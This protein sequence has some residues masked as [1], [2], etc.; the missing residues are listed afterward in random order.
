[1]KE[2][3]IV[4]IHGMGKTDEDFD[5]R[6]KAA[7]R[8]R[9]GDSR[10]SRIVWEKV[11]YQDILQPHQKRLMNASMVEGDVDW[12]KLRKFV[13]FGFSDAASMESRPSAPNS[14]YFQIQQIILDTLN[15]ALA[16][17]GDA[18]KPVIIIAQS[19]GC[20]VISNYIWDA[21]RKVEAGVF[22]HDAERPI[23]TNTKEG[24]FLRLKTLSHLFTSGCNIP[25]FI[26]GL[27]KEKI[28]PITV[29][30]RGW[31]IS[32]Q[33]YYDPDDALGWPLRPVNEAY[34]RTVSVDKAI[35]AGGLFNAWNPLSH[36]QYWRDDDFLDPVEDAVRQLL[37][38]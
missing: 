18:G 10:W 30:A 19:L 32:W 16:G 11:Y 6:L 1:M 22:R 20:Q 28:K 13:L 3:A 36:Q 5:H 7:L 15:R 26:A 8:D 38:R 24:K 4:A 37:P 21:Q 33:N 17:L 35:N 31:S 25:I 12:I 23:P 9:V 27:P 29:D 2:L 14:V 34:R